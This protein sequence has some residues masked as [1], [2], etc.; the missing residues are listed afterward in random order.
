MCV[1]ALDLIHATR[2]GQ[3]PY[4]GALRDQPR[5]L[6]AWYRSV[7]MMAIVAERVGPASSMFGGGG[8]G[9]PDPDGLESGGLGAAPPPPPRRT[10]GRRIIGPSRK[11]SN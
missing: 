11:G 9:M 4:P 6:Q 5:R 2:T 8:G 7:L 3:F 10:K 1:M